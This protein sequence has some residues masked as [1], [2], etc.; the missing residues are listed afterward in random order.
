MPYYSKKKVNNIN[1]SSRSNIHTS[2]ATCNNHF[3]I[4]LFDNQMAQSVALQLILRSSNYQDFDGMRELK[5][6]FWRDIPIGTN[7]LRLFKMHHLLVSKLQKNTKPP[8]LWKHHTYIHTLNIDSDA[9][10][11]IRST[12]LR[13]HNI[14]RILCKVWNVHDILCYWKS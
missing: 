8:N 6:W 14:Y 11:T 2:G 9:S 3:Q 12:R 10:L 13:T 1:F 7:H 4:A 5:L